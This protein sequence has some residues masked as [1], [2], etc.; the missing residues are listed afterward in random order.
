MYRATAPEGAS[1][2]GISYNR[3]SQVTL[4]PVTESSLIGPQAP[5][6][7]DLDV[8]FGIGAC[9]GLGWGRAAG[10]EVGAGWVGR[11]AGGGGGASCTGLVMGGEELP[12]FLLPL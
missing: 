10:L 12:C 4:K 7:F 5:G 8:V 2:H 3:F 1:P 9:V 11:G 6:K